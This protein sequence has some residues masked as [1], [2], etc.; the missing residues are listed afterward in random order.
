[1]SALTTDINA[2]RVQIDAIRRAHPE[3]FTDEDFAAD[4]IEGETDLYG[5]LERLDLL[6]FEAESMAQAITDRKREMDARKARYT[7]RAEALREMM[8][9]LLD[10]AGLTKAALPSATVTLRPAPAKVVVIDETGV[11]DAFWRTKREID[12]VA[13]STA[14]KSGADVPGAMLSNGG[15]TLQIRRS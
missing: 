14:L 4:V 1:M 12:R 10:D 6:V 13:L 9:G 5:V 2:V 7:A 11:P 15:R 3:V 8:A